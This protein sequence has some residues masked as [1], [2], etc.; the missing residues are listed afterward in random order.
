MSDRGPIVIATDFSEQAGEALRQGHDLAAELSA[1]VV[2]AHV[3]PEAFRSRVLFPHNAGIDAATQEAM[4]QSA[5]AAVRTQASTVL[6]RDVPAEQVL[7]EAGSPHAGLVDLADRVGARLIVAP[8][9]ATAQRIARSA[10]RPVLVAR[11]S[12]AR[13]L[14]LAATDFSDPAVPAVDAARAEA[15]RRDVPLRVLHCLDIDSPAYFAA[16]IHGGF[17]AAPFPDHVVAQL[18]SEAEQQLRALSPPGAAIVVR[19]ESPFA[20]IMHEAETA[21]AA[22]VV[23]GTHGRSG[24]A[25]FALGSVAE[26]VLREAP[27]SVLV[28]PLHAS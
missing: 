27:C 24:L 14:V 28:V 18:V 7:I 12:P 11:P 1:A 25:R 2:I 16:G 15:A 9:G 3:I 22:L 26:H 23:V 5:A 20:A 6:G 4:R 21:R 19:R 13:G 17:G 8:P 10:G